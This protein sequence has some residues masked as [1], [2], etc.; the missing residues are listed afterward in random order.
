LSIDLLAAYNAGLDMT[1]Q[2]DEDDAHNARKQEKRQEEA[3]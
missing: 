2:D 1:I 3:S